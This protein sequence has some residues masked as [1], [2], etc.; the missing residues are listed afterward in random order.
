MMGE[1]EKVLRPHQRRTTVL[2]HISAPAAPSHTCHKHSWSRQ[3]RWC[4]LC[5]RSARR[6]LSWWT[7]WPFSCQLESNRHSRHENL[8]G[9][10]HS[11]QRTQDW[12]PPLS[13][14]SLHYRSNS[15]E[16]N[17]ACMRKSA[18]HVIYCVAVKPHRVLPFFND[19]L[20][21]VVESIELLDG[22]PRLSVQSHQG[23]LFN[24]CMAGR[25]RNRQINKKSSHF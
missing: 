5:L 24:S 21:D 9:T 25:R 23:K 20:K 4:P 6:T 17:G 10:S 12:S 22:L 18:D 1:K 19:F 7:V 2:H 15:G 8:R 14:K 13:S 3:R 16:G 11:M